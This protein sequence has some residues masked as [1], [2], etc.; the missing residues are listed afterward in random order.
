MRIF[1]LEDNPHVY[2]QLVKYLEECGHTVDHS[3][4]LRSAVWK[5]ESDPK[6]DS[7]DLFLFDAGMKPEQVRCFDT[8]KD[9]DIY[10]EP[11][12]F[13]GL[14][15]LLR[16]MDL[17]GNRDDAIAIVTAYT[18]QI[19]ETKSIDVFGKTFTLQSNDAMGETIA[20]GA[21]A[22]N[23]GLSKIRYMCEE[24]GA[25]YTFALMSK[26]G[27]NIIPQMGKFINRV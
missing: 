18:K 2:V 4:R 12:G 17:L 11:N 3:D 26:S 23:E 15:F 22:D 8:S 20:D 7:Y 14:L 13:N 27:D 5:L 10:N 16:N 25:T 19:R 21:A 24:T 1:F 9:K 6:A